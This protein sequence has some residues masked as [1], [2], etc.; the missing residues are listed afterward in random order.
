MKKTKRFSF[1]SILLCFFSLLFASCAQLNKFTYS[2]APTYNIVY[3]AE[4]NT[5]DV[6]VTLEIS[7]K[8]TQTLSSVNF[9]AY[10]LDNN[11]NQLDQQEKTL[12][13]NLAIL[14]TRTYTLLYTG[15]KGKPVSVQIVDN[16][17]LFGSKTEN[18]DN[19]D[20]STTTPTPTE[21]QESWAK[22]YW[23]VIL[24]IVIYAVVGL[25]TA[26]ICGGYICADFDFTEP[27]IYIA[28]GCGLIWP[29]G[30]P[31]FI[32]YWLYEEGHFD[33]DDASYESESTDEDDEDDDDYD[34]ND[35]IEEDSDVDNSKSTI[36]KKSNNIPNIRFDDIAGLDEAKQT[37]MERVVLPMK[38]KEV[39]E[40]YGK[41]S[42]GGVLLY[43][44]P[45]TGKTMFAQAV[46]NELKAP[47]FSVKC[48]DIKSKWYGESETKIK[49]LFEKAR[50]HNVSVIFF[51][52]FDAISKSRNDE[53][54]SNVT[55]VHEI[56]AQMQGVEV[57]K[58]I[59]LILAATNCPWDIDSALLRP[60]RFNEKIYIPLPD[61]EARLYIIKKQLGKFQVSNDV[62][63]ED[64]SRRV[65]GYNSADVTEV[66]EQIKMS[67]IN[68]EIAGNKN[69][70]ISKEDIDNVLKKVK[71]SVNPDD[72]EIMQTYREKFNA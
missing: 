29:L 47:F 34:E 32:L 65:E 43:G 37:I 62:S 55:T 51:D 1:I 7:N 48:S 8:G 45:G 31:A 64:L 46:A 61:Y 25:V 30:L 53:S 16:G 39:Y 20:S 69:V 17:Y 19:Q 66:C 33:K 28:I 18:N 42:G 72:V 63:F 58:K 5:S 70:Y 24:L 50:R 23:W 15:V 68:K 13:T 27:E 67:L 12:E 57:S 41:K 40:K 71:S 22:K 14:S 59:T 10:F 4:A 21:K 11:G 6:I 2:A 49:K 26:F 9:L 36:S 3:N 44:L 35:E 54:S 52:E 38:H 60:G 56:L